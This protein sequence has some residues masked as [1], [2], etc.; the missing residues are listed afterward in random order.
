MASLMEIQEMMQRLYFHSDF[1]RGAERTFS[2]LKE[3]INELGEAMEGTDRE[4]L[5]S[6][7]ADVI[8]WIAS[9]ANLLRIDL[10]RAVLEK[11][12]DRCPKCNLSPCGCSFR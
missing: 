7:F 8:A 6:E 11:Y 1:K 12:P 10:E 3:E 4:A 5:K 9:L 2:W